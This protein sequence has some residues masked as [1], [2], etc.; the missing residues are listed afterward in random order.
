MSELKISC[1]ICNKPKTVL[2]CAICESRIC[3]S[4][5]EFITPTTFKYIDFLPAKMEHTNAFCTQCYATDVL[6][7]IEAYENVVADAKN[8][9]VFEKTQT[10]ETRLIKRL[11]DPI[12][13]EHCID[14]QEATMKMAYIAT[15]K[16]F[17][18]IV[19]T[20]IR[21][22]KIRNG[23]YQTSECS[24]TC[25][26]VNVSDDKIIKDRSIARDPN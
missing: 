3:K 23:T 4:C 9:R 17:N 24:G 14:I 5:A 16:G 19:D 25:I 8:I 10:K 2:D 22:V 20:D 6:P 26:P 7:A 1:A 12:V 11:E 18:S 21:T 15:K 13:V